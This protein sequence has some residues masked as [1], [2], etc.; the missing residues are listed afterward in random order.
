MSSRI[1]L[2]I[3]AALALACA[4]SLPANAGTLAPAKPSDVVIAGGDS[5]SDACGN[6]ATLHQIL[7][8]RNLSNG[9]AGPFV[10]PP[11]QVFVLTSFDWSISQGAANRLAG[12]AL[13]IVNGS[14]VIGVNASAG[15]AITDASGNASGT[16]SVAA[17]VIVKSGALLCASGIGNPVPTFGVTVHGFL[18]KDK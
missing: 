13:S 6:L 4:R 3:I 16:V 17:G 8:F 11:K 2:F 14:G 1:A 18:T 9:T 7:A 5:A 15:S 10:I 12:V